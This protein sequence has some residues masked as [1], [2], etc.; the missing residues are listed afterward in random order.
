MPTPDDLRSTEQTT[1][2]VYREDHEWLLA[3]QRSVS[4]Q[5]NETVPMFDLI[6]ELIK[7][8]WMEREGQ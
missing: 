6:H 8:V 1:I 5:R 2:R 7:A 4:F 3:R